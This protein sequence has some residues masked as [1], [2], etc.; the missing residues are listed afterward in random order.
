MLLINRKKEVSLF[1]N[2]IDVLS[3]AMR[4]KEKGK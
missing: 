2:K 4:T 1:T 3:A